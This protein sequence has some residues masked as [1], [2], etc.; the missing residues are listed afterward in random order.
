MADYEMIECMGDLPDGV[1]F[2]N[3]MAA[4]D[5]EMMGLSLTRDRLCMCQ[6]GDGEGKVWLVRF[7]GENWE[8]PN[9]KAL[10]TNPDILKILH[11]GR[12]DIACM[13]KHLG[14]MTAP[15]YD[16]KIASKFCR[17]YTERHGLKA[18]VEEVL[19][20]VK[21]DK[22]QGTTYWGADELTDAQKIYAANDVLHLHALKEE[23]DKRL[24]K[25]GRMH[26]AQACFDFLQMRAEIDLAGWD[27][28]DIFAHH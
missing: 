12:Y 10:L 6:V 3:G 5:C 19:P 28:A 13:K 16:T 11:F 15:I 20:G 17:T 22:E 21:L 27:N 14:I 9:L 25:L 2:P 24:E 1:T 26:M 7:D 23:L 8:A 4:I 18:L